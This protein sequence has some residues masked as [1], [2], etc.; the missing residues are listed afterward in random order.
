MRS[1]TNI[2][3]TVGMVFFLGMSASAQKNEDKRPP[4]PNPPTVEPGPKNPP[5]PA[6][7]PRPK[8]EAAYF[9][10]RNETSES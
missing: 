6:P 8:N 4:K 10:V 3:I 9:F 1:V 2:L 7:T 5:K